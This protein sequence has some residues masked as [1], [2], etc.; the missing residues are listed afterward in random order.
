[1]PSNGYVHAWDKTASLASVAM[2]VRNAAIPFLFKPATFI[3]EEMLTQRGSRLGT[4]TEE[5]LTGI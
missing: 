4:M 2:L 5:L 1:M 3:F